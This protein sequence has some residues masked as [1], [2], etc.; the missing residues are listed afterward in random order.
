MN[1]PDKINNSD[2]LMKKQT[3]FIYVTKNSPFCY[4]RQSS[5]S[6]ETRV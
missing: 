5:K 6:N 3:F 2:S 4:N 1:T